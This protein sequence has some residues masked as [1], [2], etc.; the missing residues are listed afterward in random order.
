M[1][2]GDLQQAVKEAVLDMLA[3]SIDKEDASRLLKDPE[4]MASYARLVYKVMSADISKEDLI[5]M[6]WI[7]K[8]FKRWKSHL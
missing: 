5:G 2:G 7:G 4:A 3:N 8:S 6:S 1:Q